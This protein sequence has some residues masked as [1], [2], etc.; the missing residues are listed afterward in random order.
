VNLHRGTLARVTVGVSRHAR[1]LL[2]QSRVL[3]G[4]SPPAGDVRG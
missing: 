3:P 1:A 2:G 4:R